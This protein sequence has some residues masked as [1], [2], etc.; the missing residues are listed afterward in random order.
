MV[1]RI[2]VQRADDAQ[3]VGARG[4]VR[5]QVAHHDAAV[6]VRLKLER[7]RHESELGVATVGFFALVLGEG[8]LG[9]ERID[10][11]RAAVHEQENHAPGPGR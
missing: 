7:R 6:A 10:V 8:R 1:W 5:K 3:I 2:G 11:R 4:H 9:I